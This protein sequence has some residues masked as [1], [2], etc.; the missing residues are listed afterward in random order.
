M[1]NNVKDALRNYKRYKNRAHILE[2]IAMFPGKDPYFYR[3]VAGLS[4][5]KTLHWKTNVAEFDLEFQYLATLGYIQYH[6]D[7]DVMSLTETG[8]QALR[9]CSMQN[10]A[11]SAY[12]NY[13]DLKLKRLTITISTFAIVISMISLMIGYLKP[14]ETHPTQSYAA[15]DSQ[16]SVVEKDTSHVSPCKSPEIKSYW[17]TCPCHL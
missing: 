2:V 7:N 17:N 11:L 1:N 3:N 9:D 6:K 12:N 16:T 10:L 13:L 14:T 5:D 8:I 4:V 15:T